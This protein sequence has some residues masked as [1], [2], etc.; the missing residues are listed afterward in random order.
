MEAEQ[1]LDSQSEGAYCIATNKDLRYC[2]F[3][4]K[5]FIVYW[6]VCICSAID[7]CIDIFKYPSIAP[8]TCRATTDITVY[9]LSKL[10][11]YA[12]LLTFSY[13]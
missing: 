3:G 6:H 2:T 7:R 10:F 13:I 1:G 5:I 9:V 12:R 11:E 8:H 4:S